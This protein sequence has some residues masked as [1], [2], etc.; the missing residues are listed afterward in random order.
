M[1]NSESAKYTRM[2]K[3]VGPIMLTHL[4]CSTGTPEKFELFKKSQRMSKESPGKEELRRFQRRA[5][6]GRIAVDMFDSVLTRTM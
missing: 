3:F 5:T 2:S 6:E 1:G 4:I